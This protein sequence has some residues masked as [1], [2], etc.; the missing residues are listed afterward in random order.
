MN[1]TLPCVLTNARDER[2]SAVSNDRLQSAHRRDASRHLAPP[3]AGPCPLRQDRVAAIGRPRQATGRRYSHRPLQGIPAS[4]SN[5]GSSA[6]CPAPWAGPRP[7]RTSSAGE[8]IAGHAC[9]ATAHAVERL[10]MAGDGR[11]P[12]R[13]AAFRAGP[14]KGAGPAGSCRKPGTGRQ[15]ARIALPH[16]RF[17]P[18]TRLHARDASRC[19]STAGHAAAGACPGRLRASGNPAYR[20]GA[21]WG[22]GQSGSR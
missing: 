2:D 3:R 10:R 11:L 1:L 19:R 8:K 7:C 18:G 15:L 6:L 21:G 16:P 9:P 4:C 14:G 5:A 22:R 13:H 20:T 17:H 12:L